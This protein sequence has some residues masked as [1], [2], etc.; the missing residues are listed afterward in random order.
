MKREK[1][2]DAAWIYAA[3]IL[4]ALA[5][6]LADHKT[7]NPFVSTLGFGMELA[8]E[9]G[10]LLIWLNSVRR[11]LLPSPGR[12]CIVAAA[13]LFLFFIAVSA[14]NYRIADQNDLAFKRFCWYLYY[15]PLLF[16]PAL[17]L[18][19]C[20]GIARGKKKLKLPAALLLSVSG[21]LFA[22]VLSND[23]HYLIFIPNDPLDFRSSGGY[24]YGILY[25]I[26]FVIVAAEML[27][28][29]VLLAVLFR[30]RLQLLA[31]LIP[32]V[33]LPFYK[34]LSVLMFHIFG[35]Y[36]LTMPQYCIFCLACF[37]ECCIR[38]RLIP[39]NENYTAF[40]RCM[41]FPAVIT[42]AA[43]T[44]VYRTAVPVEADREKMRAALSAPV[45]LTGDLRLCGIPLKAGC[46]F[47][48]EDESE[49]NRMNDRLKDAG[50]LLETEH[51]LI[52]AENELQAQKARTES[53]S[54]IYAEISEKTYARQQRISRLLENTSPDA[55]DF[56]RVLALV[57]LYNVWIKRSANL[58]LVSEGKADV[59]ARELTLALD[60]TARYL[61]YLGVTMETAGGAKGL[62]PR[63]V[64]FDAYETF[65]ALTEAALPGMTR[66]YAALT[67]NTL[68]LVTDAPPPAVLPDAP[69][70]LTVTQSEGL[71]YFAVSLK[72]GSGA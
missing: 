55:P 56:R 42:D 37:F 15:I 49:L 10:M 40:F 28:G 68:R 19:T 6:R 33:L 18:I 8:L 71:T 53:R 32:V 62:L 50:E 43:F 4:L 1:H 30:K 60:E 66:L 25:Y 57:S 45:Y 65:E 36:F 47:Y 13:L 63:A 2:I 29:A 38:L 61:V 9:A 12:V 35:V 21:V 54:R 39:Y 64:A 7:R 51:T 24:G 44:P 48:T 3:C 27:S 31:V 20:I 14:V 26:G 69:L 59:D 23:L 58:L 46:V 41:R 22:F 5:F 52:R 17:F 72:G 16:T 34:P 11:R 67:E 70:P